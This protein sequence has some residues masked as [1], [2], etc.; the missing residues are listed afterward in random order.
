MF[1]AV[2]PI[3]GS[4]QLQPS[5]SVT[6]R[7]GRPTSRFQGGGT[8]SNPVGGTQTKPLVRRRDRG[9]V[10]GLGVF[11]RSS[12]VR[13]GDHAY[14]LITARGAPFVPNLCQAE[15]T[16]PSASPAAPRQPPPWSAPTAGNRPAP[17]PHRLSARGP[18]PPTASRPHRT[19]RQRW[20]QPSM[21]HVAGRTA[22]WSSIDKGT[23][24]TT[25]AACAWPILDPATM[26]TEV[27]DG[28][29][30]LS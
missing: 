9:Q 19:R 17:A 1:A 29:S 7:R 30:A 12:V 25:G 15:F 8:G 27:P 26:D 16:P 14:R 20:S 21:R 10:K 28:S 11:G 2:R 6:I 24:G 3:A 5:A 22:W 23:K 13:P 18:P 4:L